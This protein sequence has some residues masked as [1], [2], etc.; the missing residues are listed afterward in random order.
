[1]MTGGLPAS[2]SSVASYW[3]ALLP[4]MVLSAIVFGIGVA[5]GMIA[6]NWVPQAAAGVEDSLEEFVRLAHGWGPLGLFVF[7]VI[8]NVV[9]AGMMMCLGIV[10]GLVPIVF[11]VSNGIVLAVAV[12]IVAEQGGVLVA[13]AGLVPHGIIELPAVLLAAA[14]GLRLGAVALERV[15]RPD[16]DVKTELLKAWRFFVALILP[17]LLAAAVIE[18]VV[19]PLIL[20]MAR[21]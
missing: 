18:T 9:K 16:T 15:K 10:F 6:L 14:A 8:N 11:L 3:P 17:A 5:A 20:M 19:T 4:Y 12:A 1:M 21:A 13:V 7:I 2:G